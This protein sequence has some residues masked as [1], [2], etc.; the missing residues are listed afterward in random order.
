MAPAGRARA[1]ILSLKNQGIRDGTGVAFPH[2]DCI[3]ISSRNA[4]RSVI[5]YATPAISNG[6]RKPF[7]RFQN[8]RTG[9]VCFDG[10]LAAEGIKTFS[11]F[12]WQL[13]FPGVTI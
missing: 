1:E 12:Q 5:V 4:L 8:R 3:F 11:V 10:S 13:I 9:S 2:G 7:S 6:N